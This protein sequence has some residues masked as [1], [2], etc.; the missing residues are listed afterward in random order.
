MSELVFQCP[1]CRAR[2]EL[3]RAKVEQI[4][5]CSG[6]GLPFRPEIPSGPLLRQGADGQWSAG[7]VAQR[8]SAQREEKTLLTAHPAMFRA[9]PVSYLS[10]VVVFVLGMAG[11]FIFAGPAE[12]LGL[13]QLWRPITLV[14]SIVCGVF[15]VLALAVMCSWLLRTRF[16]SLTVTDQRTIWRVESSTARPRRSSMTT[17][18]TSNCARP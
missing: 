7:T 6:C 17:S 1:H 15:A 5:D 9:N 13:D 18:A 11:V 16:E 3:A 8:A 14:L 12:G 10:M 2:V 4:I